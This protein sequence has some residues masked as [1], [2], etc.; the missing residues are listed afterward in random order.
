MSLFPN[1]NLNR[2]V[3][4]HEIWYGRND[5]QGDLGSIIFNPMASIILNLLM[6]DVV[7]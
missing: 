5:I 6:F 4:F 2:L 3:D 1:N 7:R